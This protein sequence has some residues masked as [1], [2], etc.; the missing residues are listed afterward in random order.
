LGRK[1]RLEPL[2][3]LV[4]Q[5]MSVCM[6][7]QMYTDQTRVCKHA[8][9]RRHTQVAADLSVGCHFCPC[10]GALHRGLLLKPS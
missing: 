9:V 6:H 8:L 10:G 4:G 2:P 5:C 3:L 7:M 1:Q